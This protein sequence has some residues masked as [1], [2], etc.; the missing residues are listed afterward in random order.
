[1]KIFRWGDTSEQPER[2]SAQKKK[3]HWEVSKSKV[4]SSLTLSQQT[5]ERVYLLASLVH[6][7]KGNFKFASSNSET[8]K[9]IMM[10]PESKS[11]H[12]NQVDNSYFLL[13]N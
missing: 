13:S 4:L 5:S 6:V 10:R 2:N 7:F 1:M 11:K 8:Q 3:I 12:S 9:D